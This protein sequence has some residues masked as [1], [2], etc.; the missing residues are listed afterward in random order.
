MQ[1]DFLPLIRSY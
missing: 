1:T